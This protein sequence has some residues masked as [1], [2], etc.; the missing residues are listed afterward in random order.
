M[1]NE[2]GAFCG[3]RIGRGKQLLGGNLP[4]YHFVHHKSLMI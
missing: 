1:I 3:M 2:F 4:Q